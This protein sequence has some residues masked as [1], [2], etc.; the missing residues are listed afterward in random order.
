[1]TPNPANYKATL[2]NQMFRSPVVILSNSFN[3][4]SSKK[5]FEMMKTIKI[6]PYRKLKVLFVL[7]VFAIVFYAFAT[8]EYRY[9]PA[10]NNSAGPLTIYEPSI[11][12]QNMVKGIV[13]NEEGKPI[14]GVNI[15][16]TTGVPGEGFVATTDSDGRFVIKVEP[17][18]AS[19]RFFGRGYKPIT[20]KP[21][22]SSEMTVRMEKDPEY[23]APVIRPEP[24]IVVDDVIS[25]KKSS[26]V[27]K[28]VRDEIGL[29]KV[30]SPKE[31]VEKYGEKGKN[32]VIEITTRKRAAELGIKIPFRRRNPEDFPTFQGKPQSGFTGWVVSKIIYPPEA[33][34]KKVEGW[35]SVNFTI[36]KDGTVSNVIAA[37]PVIP[38]LSEEVAKVVSSS[39][40]WEPPANPDAID[41]PF[42]TSV[43]LRFKLPDQI[44]T[45]LRFVVV[46]E[47][48]MYP[49]GSE[50]LLKFIKGNLKYPETAKADSI[51]GSVILR[52]IINTEG[53]IEGISVM[54]GVH[55]LLD[56]EA[57]RLV[58]TMPSFKPGRQDDKAVNVWYM[59]P[60]TFSLSQED[61][62]PKQ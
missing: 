39:P 30:L 38:I 11:I 2:L 15:T 56:A 13:L 44:L 31:S 19:L 3:Y 62:P 8:P 7:P 58:G 22:Y 40:R 18:D 5:R 57:M 34:N 42:S 45:E 29:Q 47:M 32:G 35:V 20:L 27:F 53:N 10:D 55:P 54:K 4:S 36:E 28:E 21:V 25:D 16:T 26:E 48:P 41:K 9:A 51:E 61:L 52:F 14:E 43:T 17:P 33:Q 23:K 6:S 50:A 49:G 46:D 37:N 12:I 59:L 24:L 60:V 1:M